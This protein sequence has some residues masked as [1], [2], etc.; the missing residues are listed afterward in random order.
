MSFYQLL[1]VVIISIRVHVVAFHFWK[2]KKSICVTFFKHIILFLN[3]CCWFSSV[4]CSLRL[5]PESQHWQPAFSFGRCWFH[6]WAIFT[7][8]YQY[9][10]SGDGQSYIHTTHTDMI[11]PGWNHQVMSKRM[12]S[13]CSSGDW[14]PPFSSNCNL[15]KYT[16]SDSWIKWSSSH[17]GHYET[18]CGTND[19]FLHYVWIRQSRLIVLLLQLWEPSQKQSEVPAKAATF[20]WSSLLHRWFL[21]LS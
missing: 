20:V 17:N 9:M 8:T 7:Q 19:P 13:E 1:L 15:V 18:N 5:E 10:C 12:K 3:K 6:L 21:I 2:K 4:L 16:S 14:F 11:I